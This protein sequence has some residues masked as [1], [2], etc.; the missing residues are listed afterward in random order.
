MPV[1]DGD[2]IIST[3][4]E[5]FFPGEGDGFVDPGQALSSDA[6]AATDTATGDKNPSG[7][8]PE[9]DPRHTED[10][11]GLMYL[12]ALTD[13][14]VWSGHRFRIRTLTVGELLEVALC[15]RA[16]RDTLGDN[17]AY[18]TAMVAACIVTVDGRALPQ[19]ITRDMGDTRLSTQFRFVLDHWYSWVID[20]VYTK[21]LTLEARVAEILASM[22]KASG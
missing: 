14:F 3:P 10:F 8:F 2:G 11:D 22:G 7:V 20:H 21:Y 12:G 13:E 4:E 6:P 16:Y 18:T 1:F 5:V 9:L 15:Q 17:R 19:P